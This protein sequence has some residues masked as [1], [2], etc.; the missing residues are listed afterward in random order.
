MN[1]IVTSIVLLGLFVCVA[2]S[3][4]QTQKKVGLL[5]MATGKYTTFLEKLCASADKYFLPGHERTYFIFTDGSVPESDHIVR[6]E[7]KR[8]GWPYDT[9]MRFRVYRDAADHFADCD[10]LYACDA[11]MLFVD[12]FGDEILG[13]RVATRH[14][15]YC[16]PYQL[17][18]DYETNTCSRACIAPG[19]GNYYFAGGFYGGS[20]P[21]FLTMVCTCI[22]NTEL[23]L[24]EG[25]IAKWHDESHLNR[26]FVDNPP[27][28]ILSPSYCF[29]ENWDLP[30]V[31]KLLALSKNH[32]EFQTAL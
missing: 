8:L 32:K 16:M 24:A 17:H 31:P 25:V 29:P 20:M 10:Y 7:Q 4:A 23:D 27:T 2:P 26:Y 14:P 19:H 11:D 9:M 12:T 6:I 15:G 1:K 18:D 3:F 22:E 5:I 30:F 13:E 21:E 28:V